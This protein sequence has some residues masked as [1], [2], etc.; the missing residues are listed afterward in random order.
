MTHKLLIA[1]REIVIAHFH[2][3]ARVFPVFYPKHL[4]SFSFSIWGAETGAL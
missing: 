2:K 4:N 1:Y 3:S